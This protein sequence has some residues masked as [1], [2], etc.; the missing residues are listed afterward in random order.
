MTD[1]NIDNYTVDEI[2]SI[3]NLTEPTPFNVKDMANSLIAKL[4]TEG[5]KDLENFVKFPFEL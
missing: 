5:K 4:K 1:I 3:L 2:L